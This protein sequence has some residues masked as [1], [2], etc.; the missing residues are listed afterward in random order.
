MST[1]NRQLACLSRSMFTCGHREL[2]RPHPPHQRPTARPAAGR[3]IFRWAVVALRRVDCGPRTPLGSDPDACVPGVQVNQTTELVSWWRSASAPPRGSDVNCVP[4]PGGCSASR[5]RCPGSRCRSRTGRHASI[6]VDAAAA[7]VIDVQMAKASAP[8]ASALAP[9][10]A[11][12]MPPIRTISI[13][14]R[15][16]ISSSAPQAFDDRGERSGHR[17]TP[18]PRRL[19]HQWSPAC[20]RA[21]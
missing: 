2:A 13:L 1:T 11:L 6:A 21:R 18:E 8:R 12:Q 16:L 17:H 19:R 7:I 9:S 20:R 5:S 10:M 4:R 3:F 14:W 15:L